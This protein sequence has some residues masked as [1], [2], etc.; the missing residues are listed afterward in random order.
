MA[1]IILGVIVFIVGLV[2]ARN[3]GNIKRFNGVIK[4]LGIIVIL[5]G[6]LVTSIIQIDAG[7]V[8]VK[9][10]FGKVQNEVFP[11]DCIWSIHCWIS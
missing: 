11:V 9:K 6:I 1:L 5:I 7:E 2:V 3:D 8:G 10:L 4:T